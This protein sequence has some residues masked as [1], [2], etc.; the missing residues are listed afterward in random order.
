MFTFFKKSP[1]SVPFRDK[2]WKAETAAIKGM[3]M[4]ALMKLQKGQSSLVVSFFSAEMEKLKSFM[5]ENKMEYFLL[6][7]YSAEEI[8][9]PGIFLISATSLSQL[10]SSSLLLN[11]SNRFG[12]EVYFSGHYPI[13]AKENSVLES[14][15]SKG[16]NSFVFCLS[17]DDPLLKMFGSEN[18]LP[19]LE[20]LGLEDEESLEHKM[21]T[22]AIQRA[23]E[24]LEKKV[25]RE[26]TTDSPQEWFAKNVK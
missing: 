14:L 6:D 10:S 19:L 2:V 9:A 13:Q 3:L 18:I 16:F 25:A 4:I 24:K 1:T 21:I 15:S 7:E 8:N 11:S 17:F 23:R 26:I 20:K 22:Q 12:G 5:Q